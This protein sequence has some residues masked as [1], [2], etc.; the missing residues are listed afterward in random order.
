M[1]CTLLKLEIAFSRHSLEAV[2][3]LTLILRANSINVF[4]CWCNSIS[5]TVLKSQFMIKEIEPITYCIFKC[6]MGIFCF[7]IVKTKNR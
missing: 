3:S 6:K 4:L 1:A 5:T 2:K 7:Y